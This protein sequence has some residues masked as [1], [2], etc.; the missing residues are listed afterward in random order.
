MRVFPQLAALLVTGATLATVPKPGM[1]RATAVDEPLARQAS[2][3]LPPHADV[4]ARVL[5]WVEGEI[6]AGT[7]AAAAADRASAAW[8]EVEDRGGGVLDAA[9][10]AIAATATWA[11]MVRD[12]ATAGPPD[13]QAVPPF[14]GDVVRLWSARE[15]VRQDRFD[16]ALPIL[17]GLDVATSADPATVLF[18]RGACQHALLEGDAALESLDRLLEREGELPAR[19]ARIA[20]LLRADVSTLQTDSLDHIAR[21]MR[22]AGRR[23]ALGRA[24]DDTRAV[25]D[26]V[27][28]SLDRLIERLE[29]QQQGAAPQQAAAGGAGGS[30][31]G[32]AGTPMSDSRIA[33]GRGAGEARPR[34]FAPGESWGDLPPHERE[35]VIQQIGREFPPH[36]RDAIERYFKRLATDGEAP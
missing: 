11:P 19:Y 33:G 3:S 20:K 1:A 34:D 21:R 6:V 10:E 29:D 30:G 26:E 31:R 27:V 32:Q 2:W 12:G 25:Q 7:A 23:L 18:L 5:A 35:R 14:V 36:Y 24:G 9:W 8:A 17:S 13:D 15:L 28:A 16:E 22:D 4:R